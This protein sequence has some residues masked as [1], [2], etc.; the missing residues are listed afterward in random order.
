MLHLMTI[1][2]GYNLSMQDQYIHRKKQEHQKQTLHLPEKN[3][4]YSVYHLQFVL[5]TFTPA[6]HEGASKKC[7]VRKYN[8]S[9][10]L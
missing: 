6:L 5:Q 3:S 9:Q 7:T 1:L 10:N 8:I 4:I 2:F